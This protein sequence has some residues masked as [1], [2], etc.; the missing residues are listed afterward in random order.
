MKSLLLTENEFVL[1]IP[2]KAV[3]EEPIYLVMPT[4]TRSAHPRI[5]ITAGVSTRLQIILEENNADGAGYQSEGTLEVFLQKGACVNLFQIQKL[6]AEARSS[7]VSR[8]HLKQHASLDTITFTSGGTVVKNETTVTFEEQHGFCS[9][10]GLSILKGRSQV[11]NT[12]FA[13]HKAAYGISRQHYK[14][15]ISG[16][17]KAE[18]DS[19]VD[20][21]HDAI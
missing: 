17:A 12:I 19:L 3:V 9:L 15:I 4:E 21:A 18:F 7:W 13:D 5:R 16:S 14:N 6:G 20:V 2:D 10:K 1:T 11:F 8:F